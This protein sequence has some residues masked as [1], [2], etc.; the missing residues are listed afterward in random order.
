MTTMPNE[1][2]RVT[3]GVD[4]HLDT[5]TA[6]ALDQLGR[7][8]GD[9]EIPTTRAGYARLIDWASDYGVIDA[10]GV[11]GTGSYGAGLARWLRTEGLVVVEV[12]R[13]DRQTRH[14][15]GKSDR[16]RGGRPQRPGR[17]AVRHPEVR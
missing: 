8:L 3:L 2:V 9:E 7:V 10:V 17:Q 11:E 16:R 6:V 13:P 15:E 14:R 1:E 12:E 5:H 4:T